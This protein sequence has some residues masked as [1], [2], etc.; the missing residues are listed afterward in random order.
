MYFAAWVSPPTKFMKVFWR[1]L[2]F[3]TE[4]AEKKQYVL[5]YFISSHP[6]CSL[7]DAVELAEYIRDMG[8]M[9]EQAQDFYPT[10]STVSTCMYYTGKNPLTGEKLHIP[11]GTREKAM[12]RA[13]IQYRAPENYD[14][15]REA[16]PALRTAGSHRLRSQGSDPP[17]DARQ[18]KKALV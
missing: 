9:P 12:Q 10:P 7:K 5:P 13:L 11:R 1:N 17:G 2:R 6:G 16:L 15:V 18:K 4:K 14:L 8:F 3:I